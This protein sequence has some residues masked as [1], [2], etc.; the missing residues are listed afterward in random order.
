MTTLIVAHR[1]ST[2]AIADSV[3]YLRDG[4]VAAAGTHAELLVKE[5]GYEAL[6]RAYEVEGD[7]TPDAW[8]ADDAISG[9]LPR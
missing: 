8:D 6:V 4:Q 1:V 7:E 9:G 5:P 2:V 3:R